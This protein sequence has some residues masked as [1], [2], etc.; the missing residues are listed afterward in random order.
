MRSLVDTSVWLAFAVSGHV[1][2]SLGVAWFKGLGQD[3]EALFCRSTQQSFLRLLTTPAVMGAYG[4]APLT[5]ARAWDECQL[6]LTARQVSF[7]AEPPHIVDKWRTLSDRSSSSPKLWMD[8]YLAAFAIAG[9]LQLVTFDAGFRQFE[10][11]D[12]LLL[13]V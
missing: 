3:D 6:W 4:A 1:F 2:H 12:L 7:V 5:N 9:E 10:G 13:G 8:A 11:L